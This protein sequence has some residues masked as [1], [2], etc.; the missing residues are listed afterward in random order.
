METSS[1]TSAKELLLPHSARL[2]A[3]GRVR[4]LL[5]YEH[6][7]RLTHWLS[8]TLMTDVHTHP[9]MH[10]LS[11]DTRAHFRSAQTHTH[12]PSPP[13]SSWNYSPAAS[14]NASTMMSPAIPS[15][16]RHKSTSM[17]SA[18][19]AN[20]TSRFFLCPAVS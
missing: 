11:T 5:R 4:L 15:L 8:S 2:I 3:S 16:Q 19:R 20:A 9:R 13:F 7:D 14:K 1:W 6:T 12:A 17:P 10:D 18:Q